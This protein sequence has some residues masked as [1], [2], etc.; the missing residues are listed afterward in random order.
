MVTNERLEKMIELAKDK[1]IAGTNKE[2]SEIMLE[3]Q[4]WRLTDKEFTEK[5]AV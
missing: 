2:I 3:L 1:I 5:G 4:K